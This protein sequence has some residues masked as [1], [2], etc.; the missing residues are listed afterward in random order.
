MES[1]PAEPNLFPGLRRG[2]G[3]ALP[4]RCLDAAIFRQIPL[5]GAIAP[6]APAVAI[7]CL[8]VNDT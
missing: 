1:D 5:D 4:E 2:T 8:S 7:L 3:S 6:Q